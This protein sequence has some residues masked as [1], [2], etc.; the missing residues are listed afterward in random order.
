M[1]EAKILFIIAVLFVVICAII[2]FSMMMK[3]LTFI[4]ETIQRLQTLKEKEFLYNIDMSEENNFKMLDAMIED[5][6][7]RYRISYLEYNDELYI[8][9]EDQKKMITWIMKDI[10]QNMSPVYYDRLKYIYNKNKLEDIICNKVTMSVLGYTIS[11][12]GNLK[13]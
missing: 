10:L 11:V 3:T 13:K 2:L 5:S 12:N 9:D 6:L 4:S 8:S 1:E 7:T